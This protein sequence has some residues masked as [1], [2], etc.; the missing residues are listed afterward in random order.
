VQ[1][2]RRAE[3]LNGA[4]VEELKENLARAGT[5]ISP[6]VEAAFRATPR[7]HFVPGVSLEEAYANTSILIKHVDG[8]PRSSSS[9]PSLMAHMLD[10]LDVVPG[11]K[12]LE[13][14]TGSGYNAALLGQLV[15]RGGRVVTIDID[16]EL[17]HAAADRLRAAGVPWVEAHAGDGGLGWPAG[18]PYERIIVTAAAW[19]IPRAWRDQLVHGG[20]IVTPLMIR[21]GQACVAFERVEN[22]LDSVS[23]GDC[24]FMSMRGAFGDPGRPLALGP[25]AGFYAVIPNPDG[26]RVSAGE[27]YGWLTDAPRELESGVSATPTEL[28]ELEQWLAFRDEGYC[29]LWT[30]GDE[31]E[32][33]LLPPLPRPGASGPTAWARGIVSEHGLA[34]VGPC[35]PRNHPSEGDQVYLGVWSYGTDVELGQRL[36][37]HM[38][39]WTASRDC[40]PLPLEIR[41]YHSC[42]TALPPSWEIVRRPSSLLAID[43][44]PAA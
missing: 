17:V 30:H 20:R 15:D 34:L 1:V 6:P 40:S 16:E 31:A 27:L 10:Q 42:D 44:S 37:N 2:A 28:W 3:E 5:P 25:R 7:H 41:V 29:F 24:S 18:G 19:D 33:E 26:P 43:W 35:P 38:E 36:L 11:Q 14:G 32:H 23:M 13:I 39:R 12:V 8:Q 4:L 21:G 9:Q 22:H